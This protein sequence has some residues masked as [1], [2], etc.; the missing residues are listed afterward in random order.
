MRK[1]Q[2]IEHISLDG[3]IQHSADDNGFPYSEALWITEV[4]DNEGSH[5]ASLNL[6]A[7]QSAIVKARPIIAGF[8]DLTVTRP[9]G[10]VGLGSMR[11]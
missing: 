7:V 11:G 1:L 3:V 5:A 6:P 8:S 9:I 2:I 4:W 10:G